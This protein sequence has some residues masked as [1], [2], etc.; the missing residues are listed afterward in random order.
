MKKG[1]HNFSIILPYLPLPSNFPSLVLKK[2]NKL[3]ILV[4]S[5]N[6]S[7]SVVFVF[8]MNKSIENQGY[9]NEMNR[10]EK[11]L[12]PVQRTQQQLF[13]QYFSIP[14]FIPE[15]EQLTFEQLSKLNENEDILLEFVEDLP[16]AMA[17]LK[18]VEVQLDEVQRVAES[19]KCL[20]ENLVTRRQVHVE[21]FEILNQLKID[22]DTLSAQHLTLTDRYYPQNIEKSLHEA[23]ASTEEK[24]EEIAEVFLNG[25]IDVEN[26]INTYTN[27]R[28]V[29]HT[30]KTKEEI[31]SKQLRELKRLGY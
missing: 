8:N 26:F 24:C 5:V 7:N 20:K 11:P 10:G 23:A 21:H 18:E 22:W 19:V 14:P 1:F 2:E 29:S 31:L 28:A 4:L 15:L 6:V 3:N 27:L 9:I 30:R 16:Q 12:R 25:Q 17:I 13:P